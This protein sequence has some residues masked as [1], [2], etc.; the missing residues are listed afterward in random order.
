MTNN[1]PHQFIQSFV[2]AQTALEDE[3]LSGLL[4]KKRGPRSSHK[5][6]EEVMA[7]VLQLLSD[8][9]S[10]SASILAER[11]QERFERRVHPRSVE[12]AL[13]RRKKKGI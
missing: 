10:L 4:P 9:P 2:Q 11:I 3:G 12:R 7:F 1:K 13:A 5:L 8:D 6:N